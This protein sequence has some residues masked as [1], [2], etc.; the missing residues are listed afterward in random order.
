VGAQFLDLRATGADGEDP[1]AD[2]STAL[3]V[4]RGVEDEKRFTFA[5]S[6][7]KTGPDGEG[8]S[9]A[10]FVSRS[11]RVAIEAADWNV[12]YA[13]SLAG[14]QPVPERFTVK[15]RVEAR[16]V[17]EPERPR[18]TD[19]AIEAFVTVAQGL[20]NARHVLE[21]SGGGTGSIA[22]IR[23]HRPPFRR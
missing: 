15:W 22:A 19:P 12:A 6:G 16:F 10:R 11:G 14:I 3:D 2:G 23:V 1:G 18:G 7:S 4:T 17:D 21:I 9:D 5:L 20:P 13:L 8:R